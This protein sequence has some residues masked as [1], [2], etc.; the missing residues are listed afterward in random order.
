MLTSDFHYELPPERIA[1]SPASPRDACKLLVLDRAGGSIEHLA[2]SGIAGLLK[3]GDLLVVNE[4]KVLPARLTGER[5]P[6]K[7]AELLL[8]RRLSDDGTLWEALV[9]P[10]RR[11]KPGSK[12]VAGSLTAHIEGWGGSVPGE[13]RGLRRVRLKAQG[14][15]APMDALRRVGLLPL[16]PYIHAYHGSMS[17]YQTVYAN[18]E[19]SAA[20]PTAGLHFTE[21]LLEALKAQGV[22]IASVDL[23]VGLDTFRPVEE[24]TIEDHCIHTELYTVSEA[25]AE[26]VNETRAAKGRVVAVGTT[27]VRSI[28]SAWSDAAQSVLPVERCQ[29]SLF[30]TPGYRFKATDAMVTNFHVPGSTLLMLVSAF[31]GREAV[32]G[33]YAEALRSGYRFLSFGDAMMIL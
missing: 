14:S 8:V 11:L 20:A 26:A 31:A 17:E 6:G 15:E 21:G 2:F 27:A 19:G 18:K 13:S 30:I 7:P 12:V 16:P 32:L 10:G 1:Q 22:R 33:A 29:T 4:S 25:A 5:A 3:A 28:E 24:R 9:S 23:E